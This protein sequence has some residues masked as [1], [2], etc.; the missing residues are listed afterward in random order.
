MINQATLAKF[1]HDPKLAETYLPHLLKYMPQFGIDTIDEQ[2]AFLAQTHHES[3]GY[4]KMRENM[5]YRSVEQLLTIFKKYFGKMKDAEIKTYIGNPEKIGNLVYAGR[6]GN[7]N[8]ASGDGYRYRGGGLCHLTGKG[9]YEVYSSRTFGDKR[10]V[11]RPDDIAKPEWAVHSAC[12]YWQWK[13][14]NDQ[15]KKR[16]EDNDPLDGFER[17]TRALNGG[18]NGYAARVALLKRARAIFI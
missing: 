17:Q 9:M 16:P 1:L 8:V 10:M 11:E 15:L 12:W 2:C 4:T 3:W 6:M 7:G 13:G 14:L 18:L 5:N